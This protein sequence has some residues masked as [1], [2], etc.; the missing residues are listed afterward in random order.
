MKHPNVAVIIS[1]YNYGEFVCGAIMSVV[2]QDYPKENLRVYVVDD[3]STDD[4]R[5]QI[6]NLLN[7]HGGYCQITVPFL[8]DP[9]GKDIKKPHLHGVSAGINN[10]R[11]S[12]DMMMRNSKQGA[13]RNKG[14]KE[15]WDW[16]D[17]FA[18]L[19]A[20]DE[21]I[22]LKI[23]KCVEI[24]EQYPEVGS[25]HTDYLIENTTDKTITHEFKSSYSKELLMKDCHLH[26]GGVIRKLALEKTGLF[27]EELPPKEDYYKWLQIS[28]LFICIQIPEPLVKVR[29]SPKNTTV[30]YD[31]EFHQKQY[32]LLGQ[33]YQAWRNTLQ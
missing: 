5:E 6:K 29:I 12:V 11:I 32:E 25:V 23:R 1:N 8:G 21:M 4:S 10:V 18:V 22:P 27:D 16:A 2:N 31:Q 7:E 30:G 9:T 28:D 20:D 24:L 19:D 3:C 15:A 13:C 14:I 33:K 26:S 17:Y